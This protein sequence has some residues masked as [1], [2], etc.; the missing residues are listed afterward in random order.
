MRHMEERLPQ[1]VHRGDEAS[2][3]PGDLEL[4]RGFISLHDHERTGSVSLAPSVETLA[5]FLRTNGL[6]PARNRGLRRRTPHGCSPVRSALVAKVRREHGRAGRTPTV[7]RAAEPVRGGD[8][9]AASLRRAAARSDRGRRPRRDRRSCSASRSWPS[10]TARGTGFRHCADP[11]VQHRLL[12]PVQESLRQVVLD[13]GRAATG[14][15]CARSASGTHGDVTTRLDAAA[16]R[17][18]RRAGRPRGGR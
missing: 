12:R 6:L 17:P 2:P 1:A 7:D 5:W 9:T 15:R 14:T 3:A 18:R 8:R 13:V 16:R 11:D 10:S 4:V